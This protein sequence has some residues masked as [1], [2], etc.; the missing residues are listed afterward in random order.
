MEMSFASGARKIQSQ[1]AIAVEKSNRAGVRK[2][3][4][5]FA[6]LKGDFALAKS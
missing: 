1:I 5:D 2:Q 4:L 6:L 3:G